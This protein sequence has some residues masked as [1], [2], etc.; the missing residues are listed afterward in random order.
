MHP[1]AAQVRENSLIAEE[2]LFDVLSLVRPGIS[3]FELNDVAVRSFRRREVLPAALFLGAGS[4][5]SVSVN[6]EVLFGE[7]SKDKRLEQGDI[8]K[9]DLGVYRNGVFSDVGLSVGVGRVPPEKARLLT[10]TCCALA[11]ALNTLRHNVPVSRISAA[12]EHTL[13]EHAITPIA[14]MCGHGIGRSLHEKPF[15]P[16]VITL[17]F[18][19]YDCRLERG[20]V[21]CIEPFGTSGCGS[22]ATR[23]GIC[24]TTADSAPVAYCE[25]PVLVT[26]DGPEVF[27]K[28]AFKFME[29]V[30]EEASLAH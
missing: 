2:I 6:H 23:D 19:D 7:I 21:V 8:V 13:R 17:P 18:V 3:T 5:I 26:E 25:V 30:R 29:A 16:A 27:T 14:E 1:L 20:M 12:L 22:T 10:G 11:A 28:N 4:A 24:V 9:L 15:I